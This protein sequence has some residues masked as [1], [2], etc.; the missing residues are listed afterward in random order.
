MGV[1]FSYERGTPVRHSPGVPIPRLS[2]YLNPPIIDFRAYKRARMSLS[3]RLKDLL[4]PVTR[5]KKKKRRTAR[6]RRIQGET[7]CR[8]V[9]EPA[10][11]AH[12]SY[13][14][15]ACP[16]HSRNHCLCGGSRLSLSLS[17][18]PSPSPRM[19]NPRPARGQAAHGPQSFKTAAVRG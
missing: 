2:W 19:P 12:A 6:M 11:C 1:A 8:S 16:P 9:R 17:L 18:S 7:R 3:L 10:G 4:G 5:V 14:G 13:C 15:P